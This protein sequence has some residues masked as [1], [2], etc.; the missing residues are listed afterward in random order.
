MSAQSSNPVTGTQELA[1]EI[2]VTAIRAGGVY[3]HETSHCNAAGCAG[4][5]RF[6]A[7]IDPGDMRIGGVYSLVE[8]EAGY[9]ITAEVCP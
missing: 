4:D 3:G 7:G 1:I 9:A 8:S 2:H 6:F 5:E